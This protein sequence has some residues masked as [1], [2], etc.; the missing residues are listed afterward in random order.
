M[1]RL[2]ALLFSFSLISISAAQASEDV[3][4]YVKTVSGNATVINA[5]NSIQAKPGTPIRVNN[6]LK[7][8]AASSMGVSFKDNTVMSF[9]PNTEISVDEYLYAPKKE[10]LKFGVKITKGTLDYV[11]GVIAKLKPEAVTIK[12]PTGVI[13]TRGTHFMVKVEAATGSVEKAPDEN[14]TK[15]GAATVESK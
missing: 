14:L 15:D 10:E 11:S 12:T 5:G 4:G 2:I 6:V 8:G 13:G 1:R 3:I 9:G 7:T